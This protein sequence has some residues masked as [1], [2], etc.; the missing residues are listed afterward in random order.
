MITHMISLSISQFRR[1]F[2]IRSELPM[3]QN[4]P[5]VDLD[6]SV[7]I[8]KHSSHW[9]VDALE[10]RD[11]KYSQKTF[12]ISLNLKQGQALKSRGTEMLRILLHLTEIKSLKGLKINHETWKICK[13][14]SKITFGKLNVRN[15]NTVGAKREAFCND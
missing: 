9:E 2:L 4:F 6:N 15:I 8:Y 11:L 12:K 5:K 1:W 7:Y 13:W 3:L 14:S 10:W